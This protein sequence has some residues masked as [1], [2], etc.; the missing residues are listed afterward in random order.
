[1]Q[2]SYSR[3]IFDVNCDLDI[4]TLNLT[5]LPTQVWTKVGALAGPWSKAFSLKSTPRAVLNTDTGLGWVFGV[6][7]GQDLQQ[8]DSNLTSISFLNSTAL[9][10][11]YAFGMA[12]LRNHI[13]VYSGLKPVGSLGA[14]MSNNDLW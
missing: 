5:A 9:E 8:I 11:R 12:Y 1:M 3:F 13:F 14:T 6:S 7:N 10:S 4:W 2:S